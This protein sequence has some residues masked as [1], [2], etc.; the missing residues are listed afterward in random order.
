MDI[1]IISQRWAFGLKNALFAIGTEF[2]AA[3][4]SIRAMENVE[5]VSGREG[6]QIVSQINTD[7]IFRS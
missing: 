3:R 1:E 2:R 5:L 7:M 6:A 4:Y